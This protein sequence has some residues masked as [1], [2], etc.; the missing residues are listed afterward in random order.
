MKATHPMVLIPLAIV[1]IIIALIINNLVRNAPKQI[2][3]EEGIGIE[4]DSN[5]DITIE[6]VPVEESDAIAIETD[7]E[8]G[9][10]VVDDSSHTLTLGIVTIQEG[11]GDQVAKDGDQ[12]S[13]HYTGTLDDGS[14]FDS[15][16][17]RGKPFSFTLGVGQ[18][19]K[20]WDLGVNGMKIG[21]KRNLTIPAELAYGDRSTGGIP[22]GSTLHFEVEL[23][24][25]TP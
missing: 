18:V 13:V 24:S 3:S 22:P 20:G 6:S 8:T 19:I 17:D 7:V 10:E 23:L 9:E 12:I 5:E 11:T 2:F 25:I 21:E 14:K 16:L 15:S 4:V 1:A